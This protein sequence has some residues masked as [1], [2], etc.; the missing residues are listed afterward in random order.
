MPDIG[1]HRYQ[2]TWDDSPGRGGP[3]QA[4]RP[5]AA[6]AVPVRAVA[7]LPLAVPMEG[8]E[9]DLL[10]SC[11]E[12]VPLGELP[13][14]LPPLPRKV[15]PPSQVGRPPVAAPANGPPS[16]PKILPDEMELA[17]ASDVDMPPPRPAP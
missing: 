6:A 8:D 9:D 15:E 10:E 16:A 2:V 17:P 5:V 12:P 1:N 14:R 7:A 11:D 3:A 4:A 13:V